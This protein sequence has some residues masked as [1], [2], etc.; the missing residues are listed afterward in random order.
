MKKTSSILAIYWETLLSV[1]SAAT[2]WNTRRN[3]RRKLR[4]QHNYMMS[5]G[6]FEVCPTK[7]SPGKGRL[8]WLGSRWVYP[9]SPSPVAAPTQCMTAAEGFHRPSPQFPP[10]AVVLVS[11]VTSE[12]CGCGHVCVRN[13]C[14]CVCA[15]VRTRACVCVCVCVCMHWGKAKHSL[16]QL[17]PYNTNS[18]R[19]P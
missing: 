18:D 6:S 4:E 2:E 15:C 5:P 17:A 11:L 3:S 16:G 7:V 8:V 12:E 9:R 13:G 19:F 10:I 14:I 1:D